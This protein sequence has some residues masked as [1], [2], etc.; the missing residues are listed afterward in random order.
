MVRHGDDHVSFNGKSF[1]ES[2][3]VILSRTLILTNLFFLT[4]PKLSAAAIIKDFLRTG[5]L[6]PAQDNSTLSIYHHGMQRG[7]I[8]D[9]YDVPTGFIAGD[10]DSAE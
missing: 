10:I 5:I 4:E 6:P 3:S 7:P 1:A 8:P 9:P 2:L